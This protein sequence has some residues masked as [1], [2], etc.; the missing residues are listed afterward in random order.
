MKTKQSQHEINGR[1]LSQK[2]RSRRLRLQRLLELQAPDIIVSH[3]MM[4]LLA[5][6]GEM[7]QWF[8]NDCEKDLTNYVTE[9]LKKVN[10]G[11]IDYHTP[12][13]LGE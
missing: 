8:S 4:T 6:M 13:E 12:E 1:I 7:E 11:E 2:V 10:R 3:E 5:E 9:N